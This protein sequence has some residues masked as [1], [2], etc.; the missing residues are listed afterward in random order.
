MEST[1]RPRVG[2]TSVASPLEV[3]ADRAPASLDSLASLLEERGVGVV[4]SRAPVMT[5]EDASRVG[6][7]F[8]AARV[9][10]LAVAPASWFEDYLL[11][12]LLEECDVPLLLWPLPGMET[13]ALCGTQQLTWYLRELQKPCE[14]VFGEH[15]AGENLATALAFLRAAALRRRLRRSKVG[16]AGYR[17]RGMTEVAVNELA[18][19]KV[20]GP[21]IVHLDVPAL[22]ESA[23]AASRDET[24]RLWQQVR[25][26]AGAVRLTDADGLESVAMYL[27]AA[28]LASEHR[29]DALTIGCYPNLMGKV[30]LAASLLADEGIPLGCEGDVNAA[31]EMLVLQLLSGGPTHNTDWLEPLPDGTV[32]FTH[33]GSGS[34]RLAERAEDVTLAP[35]RL[36]SQ[37]LCVLFPAKPGPVTLLNLAPSGAGYQ[38]AILEGEA[39]HAEMVFPGNPL[40]VRFAQPVSTLIAWI[41][42]EGIGHHWVAAYRHHGREIA[43]LAQMSGPDLRL[44]R[45]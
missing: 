35:V 8:A 13:G 41:T 12:D 15:V 30:C 43:Y 37:G 16:L 40:R 2:V 10:A 25:Q 42:R 44:T 34:F 19:K 4:R 27:A 33:C 31:V 24:R 39:V 6:V 23:R 20:L 11:L 7:E 36:M 21:R 29:L 5:A 22:L 17:V 1:I 32:V 38:L 14:V 26:R 45:P 9:D 18:M 28:R 3:G